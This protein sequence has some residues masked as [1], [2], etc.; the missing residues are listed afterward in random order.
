MFYHSFWKILIVEERQKRLEKKRERA[1]ARRDK[2]NEAK[3][4]QENSKKAVLYVQFNGTDEIVQLPS[5]Y[6][7]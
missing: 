4:S 3:K 1:K 6:E 5:L 7:D 2:T